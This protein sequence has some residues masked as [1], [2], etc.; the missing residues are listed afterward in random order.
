MITR[1]LTHPRSIVVV[2]GS[3]DIKKPGGKILKNII[4]GNFKGELY[5][6]NP[7]AENVQGIIS[8][9]DPD[10]MPDVDLAIIAIAAKYT[11][12]TVEFFN[13][14]QKTKDIYNSICRL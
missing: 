6:L 1:E 2:G 7:K 5:V 14:K 3:D 11:P 13:P 4:D 10:E 9:K 8:Y 12:G